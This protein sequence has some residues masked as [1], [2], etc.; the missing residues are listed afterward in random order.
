[1]RRLAQHRRIAAS[2][3]EIALVGGVVTDVTLNGHYKIRW[4]LGARNFLTVACASPSDS[5]RSDR[6]QR[7]K[8]RRQARSS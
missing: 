3:N 5:W 6:H 7:A 4:T 1:M 8:V 2:L